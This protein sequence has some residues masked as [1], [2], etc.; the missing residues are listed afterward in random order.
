MSTRP[1]E[2]TCLAC[3]GTQC[4]SGRAETCHSCAAVRRE[5]IHRILRL[6][7]TVDRIGAALA[8]VRRLTELAECDTSRHPDMMALQAS[9]DRI[10]RELD[11]EADEWGLL[12]LRVHEA[13]GTAPRAVKKVAW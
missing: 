2:R 12:L 3:G 1:R 5:A 7:P 10:E 4:V 6:R 8:C 11:A 13:W 9:L